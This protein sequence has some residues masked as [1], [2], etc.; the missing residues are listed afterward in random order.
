MTSSDAVESPV[1]MA[2][3]AAG[4]DVVEAF[5]LLSNETRLAILLALWEA[6][7]P[8]SLDNTVSFTELYER[9]N[10]GDTGNFTYHLDKLIDHFVEESEE[11]YRLRDAGHKI[12]QGVIAGAGFGDTMLPPTEIERDCHRCGS[13]VELGY[14]NEHLYQRCTGCEGNIGPTSTENAPEG[15]LLVCDFPPAGLTDRTPGE[16]F[17]AGTNKW[18][19]DVNLL[20]RGTCPA[21]SGPVDGTVRVCDDHEVPAG[22]VC[23]ACGSQ[24]R[25]R[26]SYVCSVCKNAASFPAGAAVIDHPAVISFRAEHDIEM[27]YDLEDP[28]TCGR[29]WDHLMGYSETLLSTDP[30]RVRI[31][32]PGD[33]MSLHLTLDEDLSVHEVAERPT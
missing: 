17:V 13:P 32:V 24:N 20:V 31:A 28:T 1:E 27:T 4:T 16:L 11:G 23:A 26:V 22:E 7:A 6:Y 25:I 14:R 15:T 19:G 33:R 2:A 30:M 10:A 9:A 3:G 12:L 21:C 18:I 8:E 5:K 29:L